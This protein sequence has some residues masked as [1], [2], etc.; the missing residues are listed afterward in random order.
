MCKYTI[1]FSILIVSCGQTNVNNSKEVGEVTYKI[2]KFET[3]HK[4]KIEKI[5][6]PVS[7]NKITSWTTYNELVLLFVEQYSTISPSSALEHSKELLNFSEVLV[8]SLKIPLLKNRGVYAR[9]HTLHSE[10]LRL[11]D[12]SSISSIKA[13]EVKQQTDKIANV[14]SSLNAKINAV[15]DREALDSDIDFDESVFGFDS[16]VAEDY[17]LRKYNKQNRRFER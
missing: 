10:I 12:M 13:E 4:F 15:F 9:I 1:F 2:S 11:H 6:T 16:I 3:N 14:I 8:D 7:K 17:P 5:L